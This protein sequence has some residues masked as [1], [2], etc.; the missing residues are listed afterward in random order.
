[1]GT[2]GGVIVG[3]SGVGVPGVGVGSRSMHVPSSRIAWMIAWASSTV[4]APFPLQS[5]E[6]HSSNVGVYS[7]MAMKKASCASS[8]LNIPSLFTSPSLMQI[9]VTVG[10]GVRVFVGVLVGVFVGVI[11]GVIVGVGVGVGVFVGVFVGVG[12]GV[13]VGVGVGVLVGVG[14]G[15]FV[16]VGVGV[17]VGVGV[18]VGVAPVEIS[19]A[20]AHNNPQ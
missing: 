14:V 13:L 15:V 2:G 17:F 18:G 4:T 12:V 16:G 9:G 8:A 5:A 1:M 3:V 6:H 7:P 20:T 11:V 10:D 19:D